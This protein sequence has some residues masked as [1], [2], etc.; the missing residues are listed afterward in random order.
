MDNRPLS[1]PEP[2]EPAPC[3][4]VS[5]NHDMVTDPD[6]L[7]LVRQMVDHLEK[8]EAGAQ[9]IPILTILDWRPPTGNEHTA[10][11][12]AARR[13]N[14]LLRLAAGGWVE[15]PEEGMTEVRFTP[16]LSAAIA[17]LFQNTSP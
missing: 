14:Q 11:M 3:A 12:S 10:R 8:Q 2:C 7:A 1:L 13:V 15:S 16:K 6:L 9:S 4:L 17:P 5:P